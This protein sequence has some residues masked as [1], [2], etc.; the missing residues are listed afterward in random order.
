[1]TLGELVRKKKQKKQAL[2]STYPALALMWALFY[3]F[4]S[5]FL[6]CKL[7]CLLFLDVQ[8]NYYYYYYYYFES[9]VLYAEA[10]AVMS[11]DESSTNQNPTRTNIHHVVSVSFSKGPQTVKTVAPLFRQYHRNMSCIY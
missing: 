3:F 7:F 5:P 6:T 4:F 10:M 2:T 11:E 9:F 1:M 8:L